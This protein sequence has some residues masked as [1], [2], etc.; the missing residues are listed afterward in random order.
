MSRGRNWRGFNTS[1]PDLGNQQT[2]LF[3]MSSSILVC[4]LRS[5]IR[6]LCRVGWS[7]QSPDITSASRHVLQP[8][9]PKGSPWRSSGRNAFTS[10]PQSM[11]A[12]AE[13]AWQ[14]H[15]LGLPC[16]SPLTGLA[17][18]LASHT[19]SARPRSGMEC[20]SPKSFSLSLWQSHQIHFQSPQKYR[21][22]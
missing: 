20:H 11:Y 14:E 8:P 2:L 21:T 12:L 18:P 4:A 10:G 9:N 16:T 22:I 19:S 6:Q 3:L 5:A 13:Q 1:P 7:I 15:G 17:R